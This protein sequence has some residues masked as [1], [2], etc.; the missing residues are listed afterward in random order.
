MPL[1]IKTLI[2]VGKDFFLFLVGYVRLCRFDLF[3]L[4]LHPGDHGDLA[5]FQRAGDHRFERLSPRTEIAVLHPPRQIHYFRG[6]HGLFVDNIDKAFRS[7]DNG[8]IFHLHYVAYALTSAERDMHSLPDLRG[9]LFPAR[10]FVLEG[11]VDG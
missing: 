6:E 1:L 8:I 2:D 11:P 7:L 3:A 5:P 10:H 4:L 9:I